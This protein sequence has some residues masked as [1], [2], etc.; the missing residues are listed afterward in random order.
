MGATQD[1]IIINKNRVSMTLDAMKG[2]N[3][4]ILFYLK[5]KICAP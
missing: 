5:A 2:Q 3:K 1:K 4:S